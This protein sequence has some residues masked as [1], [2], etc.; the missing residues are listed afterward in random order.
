MFPILDQKISFS[1]INVFILKRVNKDLFAFKR[2]NVNN[3]KSQI[4]CVRR[5]LVLAAT[6]FFG[7][8]TLSALV[9]ITVLEF[10]SVSLKAKSLQSP[11]GIFLLDLEM[12]T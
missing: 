11:R 8:V 12:G 4:V 1:Y 3:K 10:H 6:Y 2:N 5:H 7:Y 9:L